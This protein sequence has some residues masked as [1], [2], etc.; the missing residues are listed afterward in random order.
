[1]TIFFL[2]FGAG[3]GAVRCDGPTAAQMHG[4][5][6]GMLALVGLFC[7]FVGLILRSSLLSRVQ[8]RVRLPAQNRE[9]SISSG[10]L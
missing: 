1:M 7:K 8:T 9:K 3:V 5:D 2:E 6:A 4:G 10:Y